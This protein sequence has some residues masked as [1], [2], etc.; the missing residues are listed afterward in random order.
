VFLQFSTAASWVRATAD[1]ADAVSTPADSRHRKIRPKIQGI[2]AD[3][4]QL[5][6]KEAGGNAIPSQYDAITS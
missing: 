4:M 1:A 5:E 2:E 3:L 6:V